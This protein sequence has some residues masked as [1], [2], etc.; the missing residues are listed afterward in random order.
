MYSYKKLPVSLRTSLLAMVLVGSAYADGTLTGNLGISLTIG[1][2]CLVTNS[3]VSDSTNQWGSLDFGSYSNLSNVIDASVTDSQGSGSMTV[4]C[5]SGLSPTMVLDGGL[6]GDG[7]NRYVSSDGGTTL[8]PYRLYSDS[9]RTETIALNGS[10]SL[11]A[12]G[13]AQNVP[14]YGRI[15]PADQGSNTAPAS[16][17]YTD[18]VVATLSW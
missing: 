11:T 7:S 15:L 6:Y 1:D 16:G 12:D 17:T 13:T 2:G 10:V 14:V 3:S 9:A 5:T 8:I 4:T 18:T